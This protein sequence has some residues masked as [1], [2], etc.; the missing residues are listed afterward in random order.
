MLDSYGNY[1]R[2]DPKTI[3]GHPDAPPHWEDAG[4][5]GDYQPEETKEGEVPREYQDYEDFAGGFAEEGG[6]GEEEVF[7][8]GYREGTHKFRKK[9]EASSGTGGY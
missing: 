6:E 2:H 5:E 8:G 3:K 7:A 9:G 1:Q 4:A